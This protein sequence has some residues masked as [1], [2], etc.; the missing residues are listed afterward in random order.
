VAPRP[1]SVE[2]NRA[3]PSEQLIEAVFYSQVCHTL[4]MAAGGNSKQA[5]S[6]KAVENQD[7]P[8]FPAGIGDHIGLQK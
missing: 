4:V 6:E 3:L 8:E 7:G 5:I 2:Q 1:S